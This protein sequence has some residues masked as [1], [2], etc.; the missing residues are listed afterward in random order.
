MITIDQASELLSRGVL[1]IIVNSSLFE[2][3]GKRIL[4]SF[5]DIKDREE[6]YRLAFDK[7]R[8]SCIKALRDEDNDYKKSIN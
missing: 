1:I 2:F 6:I 3:L 5:P 8:D 7:T 4:A